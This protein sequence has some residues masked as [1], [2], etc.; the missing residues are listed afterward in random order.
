MSPR[1][2]VPAKTSEPIMPGA[3]RLPSSFIQATSV[4]GRGGTMPASCRVSSASKAASTPKTPSKRPPVGWLSRCEPISTGAPSAF[5]A[6][7]RNRFPAV[8]KP[9]VSPMARPQPISRRIAARSSAESAWRLTPLPQ[10]RA[11][12]AAISIS[13]DQRRSPS[14]RGRCSMVQSARMTWAGLAR[15]SRS[16]PAP[17]SACA[18]NSARCRLNRTGS[19]RFS[20]WPVFGRISRPEA[21]IVFLR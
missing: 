5:P 6:I 18:M 21:G 7:S 10:G 20:V 9:G 13:R 2:R 12:I 19:S 4:T 15:G 8:S 14:I 16:P 17:A 3:K 1:L 11:P